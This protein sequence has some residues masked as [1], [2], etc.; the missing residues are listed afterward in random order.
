MKHFWAVA[1]AF[2][3]TLV[4]IAATAQAAS[5]EYL[6]GGPSGAYVPGRTVLG[7]YS[8]ETPS[9]VP[10]HVD[11]YAFTLERVIALGGVNRW[12]D[13]NSLPRDAFG[14]RVAAVDGVRNEADSQ[15]VVTVPALPQG[16]YAA[17]ATVGDTHRTTVFDVTTLG[18]VGNPL[19]AT[20]LLYAVDLRTFARHAGPTSYAVHL[21][22]G[23]RIVHADKD[24]L[25]AFDVPSGE[26]SE[27]VVVASTA[28]GSSMVL[29]VNAWNDRSGDDDVGLVQTDRPIYRPGQTI[30]LRA[31]VRRG[32][33]GGY[34]IPT[35]VRSVTVTA[36]DGTIVFSHDVRI[37]AFGTVAASVRLP[38]KAAIGGYAI[39]VGPTLSTDVSILA[40]KK[41]EY[42]IAFAPDKPFVVGGDA[43]TF[44]L[45]AKY[46]FGRPAAGLHLHYVARRQPHC[47]YFPGPFASSADYGRR[48]DCYARPVVAEGDFATD[49]QGMH[50]FSLPTK[51]VTGEDELSIE[52]DGRDASGRTVQVSGSLRVVPAAFYLAISS[53]EWFA[54]AGKAAHLALSSRTYDE[55]PQPNANVTLAIVGSHWDVK[56]SKYVEVSRETRSFSTGPDGKLAFDWTP[57]AGGSYSFEA[58]SKDD[59]GNVAHGYFYMWV[60]DDG[61]RSWFQPSDQPRVIAQKDAF[62]PGERPRVLITLPKPDRDVLVVEATDRF[63]STRVVHV[64]GM[65]ASLAL[66]AP[67]DAAQFTVTV[68]MPN[69]NGVS[70]AQTTIKLVPAPKALFVTVRPDKARYAP[71]ERATFAIEAR[72]LRGRGVRA[73]LALGV[74]DEALYAVQAASPIDPMATFYTRD[75]YF[76]PTFSWFR[77]N[78][79]ALERSG[80]MADTYTVNAFSKTVAGRLTSPLS[81]IAAVRSQP[82]IRSNFQDTAYWSPSIVTDANGRAT[83]TFVWPDNLTTWRTDGLAVTR[84]TS[85]GTTRASSL[86]TK[87]FLVRLETPRFARA[88]DTTEIVGIAQGM[89]D[90]SAVS[91]KLDT[92]ALGLGTLERSLTLDANRSADTA[93]PI[94]VPGTGSVSLTLFGSDGAR[95]DAVRQELPLLAAT[96]A[97]HVRSAGS[98]PNDANLTVT[99]P[100][101]GYLGGDVTVS[102][103]PSVVAGL[104]Q[105]LR[106]LDVYPYYCTE[107]TMSAALPAIVVDGVLKRS[108]LRAPDDV[109]PGPI[110]ANAIARL[111]ELQ[112]ADGSW[113]WWEHDA[114]HPFMTA[115]ALYGLAQMRQ[116]GY[117]V[118]DYVYDR[119]VASLLSQ[120][121]RSNADTLR[122]WGGAQDGSEWNTRAYMLFSLAEAA[123]D[124]AKGVAATWYVQTLAHAKQLNPYALAVLGLAEHRLGNDAAARSLLA[125]LDARAITDGAFTYWSGDTWHYAWEDDPIET[126]AYALRLESALAPDSPRVART[127]AFLRA[128]QRGNWWYT[129]KDTAASIY[130]LAEALHP[131]ASEFHPDERVRVLLDGVEVGTVHVTSPILDAADAQIVIPASKVR[132]GGTLTFEKTGTGSLYWATDAVRYVPPGATS[133][134][135]P[136]RGLFA[137]LFAKAP[138]FSIDRTYDAGHPGPWRVGDQINVTVTVRTREAVQYVLVEDPFPAGA[139]HQDEQGQAAAQAW[140][141]VQ[142]LDDHAAFFADRLD[143]SSPLTIRYTLRVTTPGTYTAPAPTANAM[144]GPPVSAVGKGTTIQVVP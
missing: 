100:S 107:Q 71:G 20:R 43:A 37:D 116:G 48:G 87:D 91:M 21:K 44:T 64:A 95:T 106:L 123:P 17:V 138:E 85:L 75:T 83:V 105:N 26:K 79:G 132:N 30:E 143:P 1:A 93:W 33:I 31:I 135:D 76:Y 55:K 121:E 104:V 7:Y 136:D 12:G 8:G 6:W 81:T 140:S 125:L 42:E 73:E 51:P 97:E 102:L 52:A 94:K 74:V 60:L 120:L 29:T 15:W 9:K 113:G 39:R 70:N 127:I 47:W 112:H 69:E 45:T 25:A 63:V 14:P 22:D 84:D 111:S 18:V 131:D 109:R 53:D 134:S 46:F 77:P 88:G 142:I 23:V 129:T 144:Y 13:A 108:G 96:A 49:A 27:P 41:P 66:D 62:A 139:E 119:G 89:P 67:A 68:Q 5:P 50:R 10:L 118:S 57:K 99:V 59:R 24:G 16:Y 54:Q 32:S 110:V 36:S 137:R 126:T 72:D 11:V 56:G 141:G 40:Y 3:L 128:Q 90:R 86:V 124:R 133:A 2:V 101:G 61:E 28:D 19:G 34:R 117:S 4:L 122:F 65:S 114:G 80:T 98:L 35:G 78:E 58:T 130:A 82:V 103:T 38:E 92:G 115:Y